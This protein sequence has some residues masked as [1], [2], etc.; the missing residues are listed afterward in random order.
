MARAIRGGPWLQAQH[1]EWTLRLLVGEEPLA[2]FIDIEA[3]AANQVLAGT[4]GSL[5]SI[6]DVMSRYRESGECLSGRY[7][8]ARNLIVVEEMDEESLFTVL[9]DL[10]DSG[11]A[12]TA[13]EE[14]TE[15]DA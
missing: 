10:I 7:F 14:I 1:G 4:V 11:E 2:G 15:P 8:W 9:R 3:A 12:A 5:S 13:L 6:A